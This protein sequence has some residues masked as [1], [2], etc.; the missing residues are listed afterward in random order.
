MGSINFGCGYDVILPAGWSMAFWIAFVYR[1]TRVGGARELATCSREQGMP[2]FPSDF[3]DTKAGFEYNEKQ[4]RLGEDKYKRYPPAKRPNYL[5]FGIAS[6]YGPDWY[7]LVNEWDSQVDRLQDDMRKVVDSEKAIEDSQPGKIHHFVPENDERKGLVNGNATELS[8]KDDKSDV[9]NRSFKDSEV[10]S[11]DNAK[12]ASND[13]EDSNKVCEHVGDSISNKDDSETPFSTNPQF[14]VI[15]KLS[16]LK[17]LQNITLSRKQITKKILQKHKISNKDIIEY[18]AKTITACSRS[19][20]CLNLRPLLKGCPEDNAIICIPTP[21]D[22]MELQ[23]DKSY[24]GPV[25]HVH[26][27]NNAST[28]IGQCSRKAIGWVTSGQYSFARG[29]GSGIGFCTFPGFCEL[30][31]TTL[32]EKCSPVVLV[33]NTS[34]FQYRFANVIVV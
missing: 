1:G 7:T 31:M 3:P 14:N 30:I 28:V 16:T 20:I 26:K 17:Q 23:K 32:Q 12:A 19:L 34:T 13:N 29:Q 25:E 5:K 10:Q 15:R 21:Q 24:G 18:L 9:N 2:H 6:P 4:K 27:G 11:V 22:L 33:R 8:V